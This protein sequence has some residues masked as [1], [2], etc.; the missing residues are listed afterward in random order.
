MEGL[1]DKHGKR[2]EAGMTIQFDNDYFGH[3]M[4]RIIKTDAKGR[5][6]F[7]AIPGVSDELCFAKAWRKEIEVVTDTT[8]KRTIGNHI[9]LNG[10]RHMA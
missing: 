9:N 2:L 6:G 10:E 4:Q 5:L 8:K 3:G 1:F 7:E